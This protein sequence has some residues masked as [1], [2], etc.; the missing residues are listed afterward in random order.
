M[1]ELGMNALLG[2]RAGQRARESQLVVMQWAGAPDSNGK[3]APIAFIGK[4]V[5]FDT[6]GI[7][8]KPSAGM[9]RHEVGH[10]AAPGVVIGLMKALAGRKAK[11]N[12][13][14]VVGLVENMP[15]GNRPARPGTSSS[16]CPARPSRS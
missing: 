4:G 6:G 16:R 8:I 9:G 10:G 3:A 11:V 1:R 2:G 15:V 13:I 5:T 14:G 12:A 7:S